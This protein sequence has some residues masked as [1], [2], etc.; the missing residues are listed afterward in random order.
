[1]YRASQG[2][3]AP[4]AS[5]PGFR[6]LAASVLPQALSVCV[7]ACVRARASPWQHAGS[8]RSVGDPPGCH[9]GTQ[10]PGHP[11]LTRARAGE[12]A[13]HTDTLGS[14]TRRSPHLTPGPSA[15]QTGTEQESRLRGS[16]RKQSTQRL[17][18][19]GVTCELPQHSGLRAPGPP[20]TPVGRWGRPPLC[21]LPRERGTQ[22]HGQRGQPPDPTRPP[23][24]HSRLPTTTRSHQEAQR[25][26]S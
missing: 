22:A 6:E 4:P 7:C 2:A 1:M 3:R 17:W 9:G 11:L 12:P 8:V 15:A 10:G 26:V 5:A 19:V 24:P 20:E 18:G 16:C 25:T 23:K 13:S 21:P 14:R